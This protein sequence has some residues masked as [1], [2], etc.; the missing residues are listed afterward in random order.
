MAGEGKRFAN[1]GYSLPKY[2]IKVKNKS[3][4]EWSLD[5]LPIGMASKIVFIILKSHEEK[6]NV[7]SFIKKIYE[8]K[9]NLDFFFLKD[10]TKGQSET[11]L[12][13]W[14]KI[15]K[16]EKLLIFNIDTNFTS[17]TLENNLKKNSDGL[18]GTFNSNL[19]RFSYVKIINGIACETAEKKVISRNALTG[20]YVFS[21]PYFF[22]STA[23]KYIRLKKTIK[24]E[25]YIAPLYN[26][27]IKMKK[28][29]IID[30]V[31]EINILG[32]PEELKLFNL[33]KI[34]NVNK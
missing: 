25:Y 33:K 22:F 18:I 10:I 32:T 23:Q 28:K 30:K 5:S 3:L 14:S 6:Y 29:I 34:K 27:L 2:L 12:Y 17:K 16:N 24:N 20:L 13:A 31:E 7:S 21:D 4:L 1:E 11:V 9:S 15:I 8:K 26:D 19:K